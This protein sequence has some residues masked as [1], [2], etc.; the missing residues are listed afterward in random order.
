M[1]HVLGAAVVSRVARGTA[2]ILLGPLVHTPA[3][4]LTHLVQARLVAR[5]AWRGVHRPRCGCRRGGRCVGGDG[6]GGG[7]DVEVR[8]QVDRAAVNKQILKGGN[9]E[10]NCVNTQTLWF[11]SHSLLCAGEVY[12]KY[13]SLTQFNPR[14]NN[15]LFF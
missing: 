6:G 5:A 12:E 10:K 13:I 2:T 14:V 4:V 9:D 8:H 1:R 7:R 3:P 11:M 15:F